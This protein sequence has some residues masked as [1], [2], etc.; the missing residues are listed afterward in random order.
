MDP[1]QLAQQNVQV[2]NPQNPNAGPQQGQGFT[3]QGGGVAAGQHPAVATWLQNP[4]PQGPLGTQGPGTPG[5]ETPGFTPAPTAQPPQFN[6][7]VE[8]ERRQREA[9]E[10][11]LQEYERSMAQEREQRARDEERRKHEEHEANQAWLM[12]QGADPQ[13][14]LQNERRYAYEREQR[15]QEALRSAEAQNQFVSLQ[16]QLQQRQSLHNQWANEVAGAFGLT[17]QERQ[18]IEGHDPNKMPHVAQAIVRGRMA[19]Q[20]QYGAQAQNLQGLGP[21]GG[22]NASGVQPREVDEGSRDF[23]KALVGIDG[24]ALA[25]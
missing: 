12:Q 8:R 3:P 24:F 16:A 23:L 18:L 4:D 15:Y 11:R 21:V 19:Q 1:Q 13:V 6:P 20:Q 5:A 17:P 25:Q 22:Q 7:E 9:L 10:M 14:L 2:F